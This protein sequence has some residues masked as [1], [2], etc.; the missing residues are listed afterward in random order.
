MTLMK[1]MIHQTCRYLL[2]TSVTLVSFV[3]RFL[4]IDFN[5]VVGSSPTLA[6]TFCQKFCLVAGF[7]LTEYLLFYT[8]MTIIEIQYFESSPNKILNRKCK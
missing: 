1:G 2:N 5:K 4:F 6:V 7:H 3:F 8:Y